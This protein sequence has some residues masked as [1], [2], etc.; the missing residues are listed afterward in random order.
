[1]WKWLKPESGWKM[2]LRLQ[3]RHVSLK[4]QLYLVR[5]VEAAWLLPSTKIWA[6]EVEKSLLGQKR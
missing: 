5:F 1:M 2:D 4:S 6:V 3:K